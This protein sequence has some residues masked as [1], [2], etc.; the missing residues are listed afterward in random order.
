M[1]V[2]PIRSGGWILALLLSPGLAVQ[3]SWAQTRDGE[4][5]A[6][7][8]ICDGLH[9][10]SPGL[11]GLCVAYCE[12]QDCDSV[13]L[14]ISGQCRA[15][16]QRLLD[17]YEKKRGPEDPPMPCL[18]PEPDPCPCFSREDLSTVQVDTCFTIDFGDES[19]LVLTDDDDINGAIVEVGP[20]GWGICGIF[21][22]GGGT[23][24]ISPEEVTACELVIRSRA[25]ELGLECRAMFPL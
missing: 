7:E 19:V 13:D 4:T 15:P 11:Y 21:H 1:M 2:R 16:D 3:A 8:E 25:D 24:E 5:P 17:H 20:D 9:D 23:L 18:T 10:A 12:A 14:A 6:E 22:G